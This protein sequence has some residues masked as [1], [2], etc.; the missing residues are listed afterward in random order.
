M[1]RESY[2]S[3]VAW[4][5]LA[6]ENFPFMT[7]TAYSDERKRESAKRVLTHSGGKETWRQQIFHND[8]ALEELESR[9]Q[10]RL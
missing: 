2:L 8:S 5:C 3:R 7:L 6:H 10:R 9:N 4:S 1:F